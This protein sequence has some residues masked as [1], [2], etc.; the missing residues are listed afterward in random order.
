LDSTGQS[1]TVSMA[2]WNY[3]RG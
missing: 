3:F 2:L 1:L